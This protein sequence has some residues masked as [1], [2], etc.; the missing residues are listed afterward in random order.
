ME[1]KI[2]K[3]GAIKL[4]GFAIMTKTKDGENL[5]ACPKLWDDYVFSVKQEKLHGETFIKNHI[6][7]GACFPENPENGEF[8]Y[9]VGIEVKDGHDVSKEYHICTIPEAMYAVFTTPHADEL[10]FS[11]II[12]GT[13]KYI[14]SEWF[15]KS[16][17]EFADGKV[18]FE[19][20]DERCQGETGKVIDIYIPVIRK[21]I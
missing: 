12:Q 5:N 8:E 15:P 17:Y 13:W 2:V 16:G 4:A 21:E 3:K 11:S 14:L 7:Y 9:V 6:E 20:Y 1:P 10:K 18:D 19:L